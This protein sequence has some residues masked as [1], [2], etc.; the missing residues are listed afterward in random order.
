V[1]N[2]RTSFDRDL[3]DLQIDD[4]LKREIIEY[5]RLK[6]LIDLCLNLNHDINN[7]LAGIMGY[8]EFMLTDE[9]EIT[10]EQRS[11]LE[12]IVE[13]SERIQAQVSKLSEIK[14]A[15]AE[16]LNGEKSVVQ[17]SLSPIC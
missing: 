6:P 3:I 10:A 8:A 13:C 5:R 14:A 12:Q 4:D 17:G 11:C 1:T 15:L 9:A 16:D 7:P 2:T